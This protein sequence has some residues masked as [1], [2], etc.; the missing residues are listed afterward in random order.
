[1]QT[2]VEDGSLVSGAN[3][4]IADIE[5][6]TYAQD[7]GITLTA[8]ESI[9]IA[10]A[11][12]YFES[13]DGR[14][15][16]N[17]VERDQAVSW[18]RTDVILE[19]WGWAHDEIPRQVINAQLAL[20]IEIDSGEDPHNPSSAPL[21]TIMKRVEGAVTVEF[22]NPGQ[23]LKVSKTQPSKTHI[24]LLLKNSGMFAIRT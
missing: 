12:E 19:N 16:G 15:V 4:Y 10:K 20:C 1:M 23:A 21:P 6:T 18:P 7:L 3:S 17:R 8:S 9:L 14:F 5:L 22:A 11:M 2:I 24:R 13:L